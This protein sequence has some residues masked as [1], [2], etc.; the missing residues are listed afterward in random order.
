MQRYITNQLLSLKM[1]QNGALRPVG[2]DLQEAA[3]GAA[4][5]RAED[6]ATRRGSPE[7]SDEG[8]RRS[9]PAWAGRHLRSGGRR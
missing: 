3:V 4:V 9:G 7:G 6:Q 2:V 1:K 5:G 8:H